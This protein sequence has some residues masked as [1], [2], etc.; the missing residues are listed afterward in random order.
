MKE[1]FLISGLGADKR[2]FDFLDLS[3]YSIHHVNWITPLPSE[4]MAAY[5][6][7]LLPQIT[8]HQPV[9]IGVS[10]GG[11]IALE[12]AKLIPVEKVILI[13]SAKSSNAIP[14]Y[15]KI[16]PKFRLEKLMRPASLKQPNEIFFWLFGVKSKEHKALLTSIMNDTDEIFLTWAI[17]TI[18]RWDNN[19]SPNQVIQIHGTKDR[20]LNVR[21]ADYLVNGGGHLMVVTQA[22]E[23]S[24]ILK[25]ILVACSN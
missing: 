17:E 2:V 20:I 4:T 12:I 5:A 14:S 16:I 19:T 23:V 8:S 11:M 18:T 9:L 25:T 3:S 6:T 1:L 22:K 21:N 13:S 7:R 24:Q 15:F 10:F